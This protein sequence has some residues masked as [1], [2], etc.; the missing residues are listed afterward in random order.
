MVLSLPFLAL[1]ALRPS[2]GYKVWLPWFCF[3]V[4][5]SYGILRNIPLLPFTWLAPH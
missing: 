1:L 2:L 5:I 3:A 4:L